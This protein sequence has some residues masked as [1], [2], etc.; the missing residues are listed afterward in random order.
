M[1]AVPIFVSMMAIGSV[2]FSQ[3]V[4]LSSD[5]TKLIFPN[6]VSV[7]LKPM[8]G[9]G[10]LIGHKSLQVLSVQID[11]LFNQASLSSDKRDLFEKEV[12]L[13]DSIIRVLHSTRTLSQ[14]R[15]SL[16]SDAY[17]KTKAVSADYDKEMRMLLD[18]VEKLQ[19]SNRKAKR[20]TFLR[21]VG[22]GA[23]ASALIG[24]MIALA[25]E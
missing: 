22:L 5:S 4:V 10:F 18:N 2:A 17:E 25:A 1:K 19:R 3:R 7:E 11:Y 23:G 20:K 14:D 9:H 8:K 6:N 24:L 21:G 13:R 12:S 15:T 16:Y